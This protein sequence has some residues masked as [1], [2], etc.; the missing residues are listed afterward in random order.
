MRPVD[1]DDAGSIG[2]A[3][4]VGTRS[5]QLPASTSGARMTADG[6]KCNL[7]DDEDTDETASE[8]YLASVQEAMSTMRT[9]QDADSSADAAGHRA[10][11][12]HSVSSNGVVRSGSDRRRWYQT[13]DESDQSLTSKQ[14]RPMSFTQAVLMHDSLSAND[15]VSSSGSA[16]KLTDV[17][18]RQ[19]NV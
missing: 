10:S 19:I 7:Y 9:P 4:S 14:S 17:S 5:A 6:S 8:R 16:A 12:S 3:L 2:T 11:G 15:T 18:A 13:A 1:Y